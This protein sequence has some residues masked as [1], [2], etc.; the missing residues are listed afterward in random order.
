MSKTRL[1]GN[2]MKE[3]AFIHDKHAIICSLCG[4]I[5]EHNFLE[6]ELE[7]AKKSDDGYATLGRTV[8]SQ[9]MH[10]VYKTKSLSRV[11]KRMQY[12]TQKEYKFN[13]FE[14]KLHDL[15]RAKC[16]QLGL[17]NRYDSQVNQLIKQCIG[18]RVTHS[19]KTTTWV[20]AILYIV[21]RNHQLSYSMMDLASLFEVDIFSLA[22]EYKRFVIKHSF[23]LPPVN[24]TVLVDRLVHLLLTDE[25]LNTN[26]H[27]KLVKLSK[28]LVEIV[29]KQEIHS[30]RRPSSLVAAAV[31]FIGEKLGKKFTYDDFQRVLGFGTCSTRQ[32]FKEIRQFVTEHARKAPL[33]GKTLSTPQDLATKIDTVIQ[34]LFVKSGANQQV[35]APAAVATLE[36]KVQSALDDALEVLDDM[37][38]DSVFD[39]NE[40]NQMNN[41]EFT[42]LDTD[43][44]EDA[45]SVS[46]QVQQQPSSVPVYSSDEEQIERLKARDHVVEISDSDDEQIGQ[47][48]NRHGIQRPQSNIIRPPSFQ[49]KLSDQEI[50]SRII[51]Q[52]KRNLAMDY[53]I[54]MELKKALGQKKFTEQIQKIA[55]QMFVKGESAES[56]MKHTTPGGKE[57]D[58]RE[59]LEHLLCSPM[60]CELD[61][62]EYKH[63]IYS[64]NEAKQK[65]ILAGLILQQARNQRVSKR[66]KLSHKSDDDSSRDA[67]W[68]L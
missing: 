51:A 15:A 68:G 62:V 32:R 21:V 52:V 43:N 24:P 27:L 9:N 57:F 58:G 30:G 38:W 12:L 19:T 13:R 45:E 16:D 34:Y 65:R 31:K 54:D 18:Q 48:W 55:Q 33:I 4:A 35:Q 42:E 37:E 25:E 1:C 61:T 40:G 23:V 10:H 14:R 46:H 29:K 47:Q 3:N 8:N 60:D 36:Q 64:E 7:Y 56:I 53:T 66:R 5:A 2:C 22:R 59:E 20:A 41:N 50:Q 67:E 39:T 63:L 44:T 49:T 17:G 28:M 26:F 11:S 6:T